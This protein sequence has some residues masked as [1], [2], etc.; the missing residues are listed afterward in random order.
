MEERIVRSD[1]ASDNECINQLHSITLVK[2]K[3][4]TN[5]SKSPP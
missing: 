3:R 4:F 1:Y 5:L 2:K